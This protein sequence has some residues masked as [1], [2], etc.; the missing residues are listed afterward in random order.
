MPRTFA[1]SPEVRTILSQATITADRVTLPPGQLER[2]LYAQV[3]KALEAAGGTWNRKAQAHLFT[4]DPRAYLA[5]MLDSAEG[6]QLQRKQSVLQAFWTPP[7]LARRMVALAEIGPGTTVLE[8]S[9]GSGH[10]VNAVT[11]HEP[12]AIVL[13]IE[14]DPTYAEQLASQGHNIRQADFLT[15]APHEYCPFDAV[16]MN[17]PFA[18]G[19]EVRHVRHALQFLRP[20]GRLLAILS[21]GITYRTDRAYADLRDILTNAGAS[22]EPLPSGTFRE[23]GTDVSTVL[24]SLTMPPLQQHANGVQMALF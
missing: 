14:I 10:L 19:A 5:A 17:P 20:G 9:A 11:Q 8:P 3:N 24:V 21:A 23:A 15:V 7:A 16:L 1:L 13:G 12:D 2:S 6:T 22:I 4:T 18:K